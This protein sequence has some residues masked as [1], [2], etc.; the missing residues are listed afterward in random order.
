MVNCRGG[1][2]RVRGAEGFAATF[3]GSGI[4]DDSISV[5]YV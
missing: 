5:F 2:V 3:A 4:Q 1:M